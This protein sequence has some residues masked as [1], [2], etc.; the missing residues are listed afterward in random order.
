MSSINFQVENP[1]QKEM[2]K[3]ILELASQE[4]DIIQTELYDWKT[5]KFSINPGCV[6]T[7][8]R[9]SSIFDEK[10]EEIQNKLNSRKSF[11]THSAPSSNFDQKASQHSSLLTQELYTK[12][13]QLFHEKHEIEVK[14]L[15]NSV[16]TLNSKLCRFEQE[17]ALIRENFQKII[18]SL[19]DKA[20]A[21][22]LKISEKDAEIDLLK[23]KIQDS[24]TIIKLLQE[25]LVSAERTIN[26][27]RDKDYELSACK[28]FYE[29]ERKRRE[30]AEN[31]YKLLIE[32]VKELNERACEQIRTD[33]HREVQQYKDQVKI[34]QRKVKNYEAKGSGDK[35]SVREHSSDLFKA[36]ESNQELNKTIKFYEDKCAELT[37]QLKMWKVKTL[38]MAERMLGLY[39]ASSN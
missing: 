31:E 12:Q 18:M 10:V 1:E 17:N 13:L 38:N 23:G 30:I 20:R 16:S 7:K 21:N 19:E 3:K 37:K 29:K 25:K 6:T 9:H 34:L 14:D 26:Q 36:S 15:K 5:K 28:G 32:E 11:A 8:S 2:R 33:C 24:E 22:D 35:E 39:K 27:A 4:V